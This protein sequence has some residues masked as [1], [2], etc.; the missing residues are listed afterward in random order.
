ML[1]SETRGRR[2]DA[3]STA[4]TLVT[5][6]THLLDLLDHRLFVPGLLLLAAALRALAILVVGPDVLVSDGGAYHQL[7]VGLAETG[8]YAGADGALTAY[9]PVGYPLFLSVPV[10]L[11]GPASWVGQLTQ[12]AVHARSTRHKRLDRRHVAT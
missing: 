4:S 7:A 12:L 8:A 6:R 9:R 3:P 11:L 10:W 5:V 2:S 1:Y